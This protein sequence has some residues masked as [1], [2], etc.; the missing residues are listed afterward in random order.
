MKEK[1]S[2]ACKVQDGQKITEVEF[3]GKNVSQRYTIGLGNN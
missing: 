3:L 2:L 1:Y